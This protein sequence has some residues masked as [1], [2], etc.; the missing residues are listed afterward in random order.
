MDVLFLPLR[1]IDF[2]KLVRSQIDYGD[3]K[4]ITKHNNRQKRVP[5]AIED[6]SLGNNAAWDC[7]DSK[8]EEAGC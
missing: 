4:S 6:T 7:L 1:S 2:L 3:S 5:M 8:A